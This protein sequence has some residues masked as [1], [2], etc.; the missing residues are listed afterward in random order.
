MRWILLIG[1]LAA[2]N[3]SLAAQ[4]S[5][6]RVTLEGVMH[7]IQRFDGSE[8]AVNG[9]EGLLEGNG[10]WVGAR[11][12][13]RAGFASLE[14]TA[15]T[16]SLDSETPAGA[17]PNRRFSSIALWVHPTSWLAV[18]GA[19]DAWRATPVRFGVPRDVAWRRIGA[20]AR[21]TARFGIPGLEETFEF[22]VFPVGSVAGEPE[23]G[24]GG[25]NL[26]NGDN[27]NHRIEVGIS[28]A[29]P[30]FPIV[31]G[32]AYRMDRLSFCGDVDFGS[33]TL[34]CVKQVDIPFEQNIILPRTELLRGLVV[35]AGLHFGR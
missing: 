24:A 27:L 17:D 8:I 13:A 9:G 20:G 33:G 30:G 14:I 1:V 31:L 6:L 29:F 23:S 11:L 25:L 4:V 18:G 5:P 19:A 10:L 16:G 32:L 7:T 15:L 34:Q 28:Y 35:R 21:I 22:M 2:A 3:T 12:R 26:T